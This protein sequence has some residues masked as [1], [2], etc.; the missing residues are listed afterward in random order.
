MNNIF[1]VV[2]G[3]SEYCGIIIWVKKAS[4]F[5]VFVVYCSGV[6]FYAV[7]ASRWW[8]KLTRQS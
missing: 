5:A 4:F 3:L 1:Y 7:L 6:V 2:L 8:L